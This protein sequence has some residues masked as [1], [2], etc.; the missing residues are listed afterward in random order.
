M[1]DSRRPPASGFRPPR[2]A[3][4]AIDQTD[5]GPHGPSFRASSELPGLCQAG[6]GEPGG[7]PRGAGGVL[8]C[9]VRGGHREKFRGP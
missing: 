8:C 4:G 7:G 6:H 5:C 9:W 2:A 3:D 1:G